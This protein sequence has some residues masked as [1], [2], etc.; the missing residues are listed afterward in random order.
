MLHKREVFGVK[1]MERKSY[2][3]I[4]IEASDHDALDCQDVC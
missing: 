3:E 2:P 1:A 4:E